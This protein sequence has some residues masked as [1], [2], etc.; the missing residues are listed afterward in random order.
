MRSAPAG[1]FPQ[2]EGCSKSNMHTL[3]RR[4]GREIG[5]GI[6]AGGMDSSPLQGSHS[7]QHQSCVA[8]SQHNERS[9]H[10]IPSPHVDWQFV[11]K[12]DGNIRND[13]TFEII[14]KN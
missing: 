11:D 13:T 3:F 12:L 10:S 1:M 2:V 14:D 8:R 9:R 6:S 5:Q 4:D 7:V